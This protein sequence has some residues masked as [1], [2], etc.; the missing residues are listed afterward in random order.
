LRTLW[1]SSVL[2]LYTTSDTLLLHITNWSR[3]QKIS[4]P[5]REKYSPS[6]LR[7]LSQWTTS[8]TSPL[9]DYPAEGK[10]REGK[11]RDNSCASADAERVSHPLDDDFTDWWAAYPRKRGKGQAIKAYRA[12][13]KKADAETLLT[14]LR[15]QTPTL[16]AKG[17]EFVPYPAT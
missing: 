16:T 7:K 15:R 10:G 3:H 17:D 6:D 2:S 11:G 4:N 14:A 13:R 5:A 9:E 12:A 1:E 8:L